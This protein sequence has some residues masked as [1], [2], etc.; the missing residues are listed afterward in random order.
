MID[1]NQTR[2]RLRAEQV[3][4]LCQVLPL[5]IGTSLLLAT[6]AAVIFW[7]HANHVAVLSWCGL[8]AATSGW[9]LGIIRRHARLRAREFGDL[10]RLAP[11]VRAGS[12]AAGVS[13][14]LSIL[15]LYQSGD[16]VHQLFLVFVLAGVTAGS[17]ITMAVDR[18]VALYF[19]MP[20][21]LPLVARL[22][23]EGDAI[24]LGMSAMV[25]L[26]S[27]FLYVSVQRLSS[28]NAQNIELRLQALQREQQLF[29]SETRFRRLAQHDALTGLPNRLSL[30]ASLPPLLAAAA[31][32][33][34]RVALLYLDL[35]DFKDVNDSRGHGCGDQMLVAVAQRLRSCVRADDLVARVGG[36]EFIVITQRAGNHGDVEH[37]AARICSALAS[38]LDI[39][40]EPVSTC[41]SI[42]IGV[43][44]EDGADTELLM[45]HA[46]IALYQA[47]AQGRNSYQF[48]AATM[49]AAVAERVYLERAL[50]QALDER[51]IYVE[52]QPLVSLGTGVVTGLEALARW[53]HP[54]RGVI[55]PVIFIAIAERCGKIERLGELILREVA[56]E[57]QAWQADMLPA[58]PV[59][60]NVSPR[61]LEGDRL[62]AL[63]AAVTEEFG[64]DPSL[65]Q[66]EITESMLMS[67]ASGQLAALGALRS[68][69]IR[70][71]IDDFG[72][73]YSSLSYLKHLPIDCIKIDRSF[74]RDMQSDE[75]DAA[76]VSAIVNIGHSLGLR[77]VAEGVETAHQAS[78]LATLGC[79]AAQGYYYF[80]PLGAQQCRELLLQQAR[81]RPV[82]DT[83]KLRIQEWMQL[84][85]R[86][87]RA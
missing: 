31:A 3:S 6:I 52:Y 19:Q 30:Q 76:I 87:R 2:L 79:D 47:K 38:P 71:S 69:G 67:H 28:H 66:A 49:S 77:V 7:P 9:R 60:I 20:V 53:R 61:Q 55:S 44:P 74:V 50:V 26:Y 81:Q 11:W 15:L 56:R 82:T 25:L 78:R 43:Y 34:N 64:I 51:Q 12:L 48:Y 4:Q 75:R 5:S 13:W 33:G 65:L 36:D 8:L 24:H 41:A 35:D 46:D 84:P 23:L 58:I 73:G 10:L 1:S 39:E 57:I 40:G 27:T 42:G 83:L 80:R 37:L 63:I 70:V 16:L 54:E 21:L 72:T 29:E 86:E 32:S 14:G 62:A 18:Q 59:A 17:A 45:K 22:A 85:T 68:L